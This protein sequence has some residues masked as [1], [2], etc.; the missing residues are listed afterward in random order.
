MSSRNVMRRLVLAVLFGAAQAVGATVIVYQNE[1]AFLAATTGG[2][3]LDFNSHPVGPIAGTEF[4][5]NGF[6]FAS[7]LSGP[8]GQ[9]EIAPP[10]FFAPTRYLNIGRRPFAPG[11]DGNE[12]NLTITIVGN[13][14]AVGFSFIDGVIPTPPFEFIDV[15]DQSSTNILHFTGPAAGFFGVVADVNIGRIFVKEGSFDGDDVGY[16]NFRLA[17]AGE[18]AA[19]EPGAL[20]LQ[21][22]GLLLL[23]GFAKGAGRRT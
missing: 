8:P 19:P 11:E 23:A 3:L 16:D 2:S 6:L 5:G 4:A 1:A 21:A 17:N 13:W 14:R 9:L 15:S 18:A 7:P 12:D 22:L 20:L 10:D